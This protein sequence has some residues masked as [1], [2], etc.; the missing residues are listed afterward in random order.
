VQGT[1]YGVQGINISIILCIYSVLC[2]LYFVLFLG[3]FYEKRF[4]SDIYRGW[5][6]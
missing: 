6:G 5:E 2:T 3:A 4:A 1:G